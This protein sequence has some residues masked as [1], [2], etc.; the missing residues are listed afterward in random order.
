MYVYMFGVNSKHDDSDIHEVHVY[1]MTLMP[2]HSD[3]GMAAW[4]MGHGYVAILCRITLSAKNSVLLY[5]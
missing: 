1:P 2:L 4:T 3:F 5:F